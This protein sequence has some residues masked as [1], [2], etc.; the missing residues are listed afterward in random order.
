M[1]AAAD[2]QKLGHSLDNCEDYYLDE[3]H[4]RSGWLGWIQPNSGSTLP[5]SVWQFDRL[6]PGQSG[7]F[8]VLTLGVLIPVIYLVS[9]AGR[10]KRTERADP[11]NGSRL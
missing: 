9:F 2:G 7:L 6:D 11:G 10:P 4:L 8:T 1:T 3:R 5:Y